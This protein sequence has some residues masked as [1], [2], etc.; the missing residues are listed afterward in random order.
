MSTGNRLADRPAT[1]YERDDSDGEPRTRRPLRKVEIIDGDSPVQ[2][3]TP[4]AKHDTKNHIPFR[5]TRTLTDA[6]ASTA[7]TLDNVSRDARGRRTP[8]KYRASR[9][10]NYS[11]GSPRSNASTPRIR[12]WLKTYRRLSNGGDLAN[13]G[14]D[15]EGD[16]VYDNIDPID[17]LSPSPSSRHRHDSNSVYGDNSSFDFMNFVMDEPPRKRESRHALDQERL[18]RVTERGTPVLSKAKVGAKHRASAETLPSD[19]GKEEIEPRIERSLNIPRT[20]GQRRR[21]SKEIIDRMN[22]QI[23]EDHVTEQTVQEWGNDMDFTTRSLT[24]STSPPVR[25]RTQ[26]QRTN[27][28]PPPLK[29]ESNPSVPEMQ[30]KMEEERT[31]SNSASD[32]NPI[33]DTPVNIYKD[34]NRDK[35]RIVKRGDSQ[36]LLRKLARTENPSLT[37]TPE[38]KSVD[39]TISNM[40]TPVVT[41]AWIDTPAPERTIDPSEPAPVNDNNTSVNKMSDQIIKTEPQN[42]EGPQNKSEKLSSEEAKPEPRSVRRTQREL[43]KP[44]LPKSALEA[45]LEEVKAGGDQ[46]LILGENTIDSLQEL[47]DDNPNLPEFK[48]FDMQDNKSPESDKESSEED[49]VNTY[50]MTDEALIDRLNTKLLS[51]VRNIKEVRDGLSSLET[52]ATKDVAAL[53]ARD[54]KTRKKGHSCRGRG[55]PC[56][57]CGLAGD[58]RLYFAIPLPRLW[59]RRPDI[60]RIRPTLLGWFLLAALT[61]WVAEVAMCELY[62]NPL[63]LPLGTHY[64][65]D[66]N[67]PQIPWV[68]P[69]MLWRWSH[70]GPI[71]APSWS[72]LVVFYRLFAQLF[73]FWDGFVDSPPEVPFPRPSMDDA[74]ANPVWTKRG[75]APQYDTPL[76]FDRPLQYKPPEA[77][78]P[79]VRGMWGEDDGDQDLSMDRDE[80]V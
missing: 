73:G 43:E 39:D 53:A 36:E 46:S 70:L 76:G 34:P 31:T 18:R 54:E 51:L 71:L 52:Q 61:W 42:V 29:V 21:R 38:P 35:P 74:P 45:V 17:P 69:T 62:C 22:R 2:T 19:N 41:G 55:E 20:W 11:T 10:M 27:R 3:R 14:N 56:E 58:G 24:V 25:N 37:N 26:S 59:H 30:S 40:K 64:E 44:K 72:I 57:T 77:H 75:Y 5:Q 8:P 66:P 67:A 13:L 7:P 49:V 1:L 68:I 50:P 12:G 65:V 9:E 6:F 32:G 47:L 33:P 48:G 28:S 78:T 79:L 16:M 63:Y 23:E 80:I 60:K 4:N 15:D